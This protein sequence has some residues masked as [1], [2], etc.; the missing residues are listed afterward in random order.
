MPAK[1]APTPPRYDGPER[2]AAHVHTVRTLGADADAL[3]Y[4][5]NCI[6][7]I[8]ERLDKGS[9]RMDEMQR[10]LS[11]NTTVTTEVRDLL[12]MGRAGIKVLAFIGKAGMALA[13]F[14]AFLGPAAGF[15]YLAYYAL[16]HGGQLPPKT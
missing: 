11:A 12:E 5:A 2:R 1:D 16:T 8:D 9:D 10:E 4:L 3:E 6:S 13:R 14:F 7:R 15:L